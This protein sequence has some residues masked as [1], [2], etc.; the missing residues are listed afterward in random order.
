[1]LSL[2][3]FSLNTH[4]QIVSFS[5]GSGIG[6]SQMKDLKSLENTLLPGLP[7]IAKVVNNFPVF[8]LY[9]FKVVF[10]IRYLEIGSGYTFSSAGSKIHHCDYS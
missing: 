1:M 2:I 6:T 8:P 3:L 7:V 5:F 9:N 10:L 4:N